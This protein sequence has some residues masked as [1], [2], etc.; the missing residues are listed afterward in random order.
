MFQQVSGR[1]DDD[2]LDQQE[3]REFTLQPG[4]IDKTG[5]DAPRER[6]ELAVEADLRGDGAADA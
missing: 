2:V 1:E 4:Q 3:N 6:V 5:R